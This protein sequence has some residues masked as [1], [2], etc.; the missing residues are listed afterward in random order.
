MRRSRLRRRCRRRGRRWRERR[1]GRR[2]D[3]RSGTGGRASRRPHPR[4]P[5]I[6]CGRPCFIRQFKPVPTNMPPRDCQVRPIDALSG[7]SSV[8]RRRRDRAV[9]SK[10]ADATASACRPGRTRRAVPRSCRR[11]LRVGKPAPMPHLKPLLRS[12]SSGSPRNIIPAKPDSSTRSLSSLLTMASM[13]KSILPGADAL[14]VVFRRR[15]LHQ[16]AQGEGHRLLAPLRRQV[17]LGAEPQVAEL[18]V[19]PA[20]VDEWV[21]VDQAAAL[22]R[23]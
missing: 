16:S 21:I 22:D 3:S 14:L 4:R 1:C 20:V 11:F 5:R 19:R 6:R 10:R 8:G 13:A 23:W 18:V 17:D 2:G 7:D 9:S 15:N 12:T